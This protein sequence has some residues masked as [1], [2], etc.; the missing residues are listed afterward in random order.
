MRRLNFFCIATEWQPH[1]EELN[2]NANF[3]EGEVVSVW[4]EDWED[5]ELKAVHE[6]RH[7]FI[8]PVLGR[9]LKIGFIHFDLAS[10][11]Q[12]LLFFGHL[13]CSALREKLEI[14]PND[15]SSTIMYQSLPLIYYIV[16]YI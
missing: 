3:C 6:L 2:V 13:Y 9:Q 15:I 12:S 16:L 4:V 14:P 8:I 1:T 10:F 5:V 7:R 11:H